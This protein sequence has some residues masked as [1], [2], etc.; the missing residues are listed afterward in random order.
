MPEINRSVCS[1]NWIDL[2][3][4]ERER[5][6]QRAMHLGIQLQVAGVLLP[7]TISILDT[8]GVDRSQKAV[9]D[10]VQKVSLQLDGGGSPNQVAVDER[11]IRIGDQQYCRTPRSTPQRTYFCMF[12]FSTYTTAYQAMSRQD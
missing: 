2:D 3:F 1:S 10:W 7:A 8:L 9:H 5:T 11:V 6:P 4:V 12:V